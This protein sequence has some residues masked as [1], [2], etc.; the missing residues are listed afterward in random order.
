MDFSEAYKCT[1]LPSYS[2]DGRYLAAANEYRVIIR[3]VETLTVVQVY[4][5]LDKI[6]YIEWSPNSK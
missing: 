1:L 5:C 3:D 4:S 2:P 6:H